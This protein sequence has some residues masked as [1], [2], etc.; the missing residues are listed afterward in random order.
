MSGSTLTSGSENNKVKISALPRSV[1]K[2]LYSFFRIAKFPMNL[3][4]AMERLCQDLHILY[5]KLLGQNVW[6][7]KHHD[8]KN[9]LFIIRS[10]NLSSNFKVDKSKRQ[11][12]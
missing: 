2:Y 7:L 5:L 4:Q 9:S 8:Q 12:N 11:S 6:M 1:S 3:V 10:K